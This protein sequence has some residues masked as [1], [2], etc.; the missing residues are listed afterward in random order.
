MLIKNIY[1]SYKKNLF[2]KK[3]YPKS[4]DR[5]YFKS[6]LNKLKEYK[7]NDAIHTASLMT[8]FFNYK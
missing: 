4:L 6:Y 3:K 1:N 7:K 2:F 5:N 8:V